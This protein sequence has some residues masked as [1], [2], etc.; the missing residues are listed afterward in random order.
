MDLPDTL[1][2]RR[3][4]AVSRAFYIARSGRPGPVVLDFTKSA[5]TEKATY[6]PAKVD[7][8]RSYVPVP[9]TSRTSIEEAAKLINEAE[10]PLV[11]VG[12]GVEL[13]DAREELR[14]FIE[15]Q[16]HLPDARSS[17]FRLYPPAI[18]ST[19]ACSACTAVWERTKH[20]EM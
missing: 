18:R 16:E 1:R 10:R 12:Q 19:W 9:A 7:Y 4:L 6:M 5:Q 14:T 3:S 13:G 20:A 11:L 15:K 2:Q 8:I 17:V